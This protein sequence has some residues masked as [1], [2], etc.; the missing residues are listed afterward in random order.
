[1]KIIPD[2][3]FVFLLM[4]RGG[5]TDDFSTDENTLSVLAS[6]F[7]SEFASLT[8]ISKI[9]DFRDPKNAGHFYEVTSI[10]KCRRKADGMNISIKLRINNFK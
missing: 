7:V 8:R 4:H 10:T 1:M 9:I 2:G 5:G 3:N 6:E